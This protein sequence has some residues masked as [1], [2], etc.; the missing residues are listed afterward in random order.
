MKLKCSWCDADLPAYRYVDRVPFCNAL[1]Q[2]WYRQKH[3][4][5]PPRMA[6]VPTT[7]P[8]HILAP[9][10]PK[11]S[12]PPLQ[13]SA[14]VVT[15]P[16][17]AVTTHAV[18]VPAPPVVIPP[19]LG[20]IRGSI[21]LMYSPRLEL[22]KI[23]KTERPLIARLRAVRVDIKDPDVELVFYLRTYRI[24]QAEYYMHDHFRDKRVLVKS[25]RTPGLIHQEWFKLDHLDIAWIGRK[26]R[27]YYL[28]ELN[29]VVS[30]AKRQL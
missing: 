15:I 10:K 7:K 9:P 8:P 20:P 18:I 14:P 29:E 24:A 17:P 5:L 1:C 4:E 23:G 26:G 28:T 6:K 19:A 13:V 2:G 27:R 21:Y 22:H 12:S 30:M 16:L 25:P 11:I 3:G